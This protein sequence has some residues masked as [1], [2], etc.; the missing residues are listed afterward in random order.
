MLAAYRQIVATAEAF[1]ADSLDR[2]TH[3]FVEQQGVKLGDMVLA[4]RVAVTGKSIGLGL[5]D[6]M[7]ILG[8]QSCLARIDQTLAKLPDNGV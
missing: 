3:G 2:L 7:A 1:D 5:Y 8:Q 6:G 4:V